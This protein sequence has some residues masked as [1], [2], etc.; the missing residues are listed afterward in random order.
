MKSKEELQERAQ[1]IRALEAACDI[2][3]PTPQEAN[4]RIALMKRVAVEFNLKELR[5]ATIEGPVGRDC[6]TAKTPNRS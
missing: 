2:Q 5:A 4:F 6:A 1:L 3:Y